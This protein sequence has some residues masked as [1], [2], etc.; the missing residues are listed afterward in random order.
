MTVRCG[1]TG[2]LA[3]YGE[4]VTTLTGMQLNSH[5]NQPQ[6]ASALVLNLRTTMQRLESCMT[7][8]KVI[9]KDMLLR[10]SSVYLSQVE[11]SANCIMEWTLPQKAWNSQKQDDSFKFAAI[12]LQDADKADFDAWA[13]ENMTD[14]EKLISEMAFEGYKLSLS[15][16]L[17]NQCFIV[18]YTNRNPDHP[19][20]NTTVSSRSD[21]WTE[22]L[23][24]TA[25]KLRRMYPDKPLPTQRK[26]NNWG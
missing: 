23:H 8:P 13:A 17:E 19:H 2:S 4:P 20:Y 15:A 14:D 18:S 25:F 1:E 9:G 7:Y 26:K 5:M 21:D 10:R 11:Y 6:L 16:D 24:M 12:T 3:K 22:A